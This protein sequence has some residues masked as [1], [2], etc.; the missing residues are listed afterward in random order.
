MVIKN[1]T[2]REQA[3][4]KF[5]PTKD[6]FDI[7][8][9]WGKW[10]ALK[11]VKWVYDTPLAPLQVTIVALLFGILAACFLAREGYLF[12]FIGAIFIQLK[13]I[14]DTVDGSLARARNTPSRIGRFL[15]SIADFITNVA[16]FVGIAWHLRI[17][18]PNAVIWILSATAFLSSVLQCSYYV[19]YTISYLNNL[20][21][22][23]VNRVDESIR[24]DDYTDCNSTQ[25]KKLLIIFH[26]LFLLFYGWQDRLAIKIDRW[27]LK[28]FD[29]C[30]SN[31]YL[32][33][34]LLTMTSWLGLGMQLFFMTLFVL[35]NQLYFYLWFV[36]IAGNTYWFF[37]VYYRVYYFKGEKK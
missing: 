19:F 30:P 9:I 17:Q 36:I 21:R 13:N 32:N 10:P 24:K 4:Q 6:F 29:N 37:L 5:D 3:A 7:S 15:D 28:H 20:N 11:I 27:S 33:R 34:K 16:L 23:T 22:L 35:L 8:A 1:K 25:E 2:L 14:F 26:K 31:W 12:L 18:Y